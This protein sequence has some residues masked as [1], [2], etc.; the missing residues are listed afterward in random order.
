MRNLSAEMARY[1]VS[2]MDIQ[3]LLG[4]SSKTDK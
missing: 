2:N 1:G 3:S 4:C